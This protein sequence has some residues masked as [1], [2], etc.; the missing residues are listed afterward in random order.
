MQLPGGIPSSL[1]LNLRSL[2]LERPMTDRLELMTLLLAKGSTDDDHPQSFPTKLFMHTSR[3][4]FKTQCE[5]YRTSSR[6]PLVV[7]EQ[8]TFTGSLITC[9]TFLNGTTADCPGYCERPFAGMTPNTLACRWMDTILGLTLQP[10]PSSNS[11]RS[12]RLSWRVSVFWKPWVI[13]WP[14]AS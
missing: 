9:W 7:D 5:N 6:L 4:R 1:L 12:S 3:C 2:F 10:G 13:S 11:L 14:K 8:G